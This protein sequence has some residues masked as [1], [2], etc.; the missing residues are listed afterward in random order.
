MTSKT[1]N[2]ICVVV[3]ML[4]WINFMAFC[5]IGQRIGGEAIHGKVESGHYFLATGYISRGI[6]SNPAIPHDYIEVPPDIFRYSQVHGYSVL[7]MFPL[8]LIAALLGVIHDKVR[9]RELAN[10][11]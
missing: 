6:P 9:K 1:F 7:V 3:F 4:G 2:R 8:A 10:L 11:A 5:L